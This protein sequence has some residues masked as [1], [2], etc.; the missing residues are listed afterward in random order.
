VDT[1]ALHG[2]AVIGSMSG[3][4]SWQ[5]SI[6]DGDNWSA[7]EAVGTNSALLLRSIDKLRFVPDAMNGTAASLTFLAW[8]QTGTTQDGQGTKVDATIN[9]GATPFSATTTTSTITAT[10]V[11]DAPTINDGATVTL[12]TTD[13][14][15]PSPVTPV[16]AILAGVG[17]GDVDVGAMNGIAVTDTTGSGTWQYSTGGTAF[18]W[19]AAPEFASHQ[20]GTS[21]VWEYG[22]AYGP[23]YDDFGL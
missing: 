18:S 15:T 21:G 1:G 8:D 17:W 10:D 9:G 7:V 20:G 14:D 6:D 11:N 13:E 12:T 2:I 23:N 3:N 22:W 5:Y 16:S 4:G 19:N